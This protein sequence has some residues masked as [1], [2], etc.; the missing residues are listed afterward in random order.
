M[1]RLVIRLDRLPV[2]VR[3]RPEGV[4]VS[5]SPG[6]LATVCGPRGVR[7]CGSAGRRDVRPL[8]RGA[9]ERRR[10]AP[11]QPL[12]VHL[13]LEE[14]R[15]T[16]DFSNRVP[17]APCSTTGGPRA[18]R[19]DAV[20]CTGGE[21]ALR[22]RG[23]SH[24]RQGDLV[25]VH[26]YQLIPGAGMLASACPDA[27]IGFFSTSVPGGPR[28]WSAAVAGRALDGMLAPT[29]SGSTPSAT[30]TLRRR[31][32][33]APRM[34][35]APDRVNVRGR[36]PPRHLSMGSTP[37]RSPP[38]P[39]PGGGGGRARHPPGGQRAAL[40]GRGPARL[41]PGHPRRLSRPGAAP[42]KRGSP[43]WCGRLKLLQDRR[44]LAHHHREY[45]EFRR[46]WTE[47]WA[48]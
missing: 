15:A 25:W 32:C 9:F 4:E 35:C 39:T 29:W 47:W 21:R 12:P 36:G 16:T 38:S 45:A 2:T 34:A 40:F 1:A 7:G 42:S 10:P 5:Q 41:P 13:S 44:A 43:P 27:R 20:S 48:R 6:G 14:W 33:A 8:A 18:A 24:L 28:C 30:S 22:R 11:G 46:T 23:A 17:V 19:G 26:D 37:R 31:R 3:G